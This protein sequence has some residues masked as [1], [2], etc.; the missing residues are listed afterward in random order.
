MKLVLKW[1]EIGMKLGIDLYWISMK[2]DLTSRY[3]LEK[4]YKTYFSTSNQEPQ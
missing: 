2:L 4:F 3:L 1:Y